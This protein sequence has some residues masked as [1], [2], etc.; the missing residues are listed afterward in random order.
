MH[1][2]CKLPWVNMFFT[3]ATVMKV[4]GLY[5]NDGARRYEEVE[6][7]LNRTTV[8]KFER[9]VRESGLQIQHSRYQFV[10]G[11]DWL[12]RIPLLRELFVN[13]VSVTLVRGND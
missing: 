12:A 11:Q 8:R 1:F 2:F 3:E 13:G 9:I 6:S 5:R 7:G 4:R 10:K